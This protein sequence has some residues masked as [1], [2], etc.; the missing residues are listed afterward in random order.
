M[1]VL[2]AGLTCAGASS[3][4]SGA[5][6]GH[7]SRSRTSSAT[8]EAQN[9]SIVKPLPS[10]CHVKHAATE[11]AVRLTHSVTP[12]RGGEPHGFVLHADTREGLRFTRRLG[13]FALHRFTQNDL[14]PAKTQRV[15]SVPILVLRPGCGLR[16]RHSLKEHKKL[17]ACQRC[18]VFQKAESRVHSRNINHRHRSPYH[19]LFDKQPLRSTTTPQISLQQHR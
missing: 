18:T 19:P 14:P 2:R 8:S 11:P 9:W 15:G 1:R 16:T 12:S 6:Q 5:L 3:V 13:G 17:K 4:L 10:P 7:L